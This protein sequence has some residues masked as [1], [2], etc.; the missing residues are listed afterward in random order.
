M[1]RRA[2]TSTPRVGSL[3]TRSRAPLSSQ[4]ATTT[5][6][7]LPPLSRRMFRGSRA[8]RHAHLLEHTAGP[9]VFTT[10]VQQRDVAVQPALVEGC[11]GD[12]RHH[13]LIRENALVSSVLGDEGYPAPGRRPRAGRP[14]PFTIEGYRPPHVLGVT[15]QGAGHLALARAQQS[16]EPDHLPR[17][18]LERN[19]D[20]RSPDAKMLNRQKGGPAG[21]AA[22]LAPRNAARGPT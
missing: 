18:D 21:G 9:G 2:P 13:R 12:V 15:V 7:W 22:V 3:Q 4:R 6:C 14:E 19:I 8:L 16:A 5:F 10:R 1:S 17:A 20:H 11:R